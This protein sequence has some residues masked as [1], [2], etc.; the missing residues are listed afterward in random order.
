MA[1]EWKKA[2][3]EKV[4][5]QKR[6]WRQRHNGEI[7][8]TF[9]KWKA[10]NPQYYEGMRTYAKDY[11]QKNAEQTRIRVKAQGY[12]KKSLIQQRGN[13]C[14]V[15]G[16]VPKNLD[17]HHIEYE[18]KTDKVLLLCRSCHMLIHKSEK[19]VKNKWK[20]K[21]KTKSPGT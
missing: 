6:R 19:G 21:K 14:Q 5:E 16:I 4:K 13:K 15:C 3:P 20:N 11:A 12:F 10:K 17:L 2:N 8:Q 7:L 18:N 1:N 9:N